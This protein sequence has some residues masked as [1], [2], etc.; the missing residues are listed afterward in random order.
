MCKY[1]HGNNT[2]NIAATILMENRLTLSII[3]NLFLYVCVRALKKIKQ[4]K[5]LSYL[6]QSYI[7]DETTWKLILLQFNVFGEKC[8]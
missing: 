7:T 4:E 1:F 6:G 5:K 3:N 2:K 8:T